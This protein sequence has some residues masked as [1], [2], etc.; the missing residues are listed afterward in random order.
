MICGLHDAQR[1][2]IAASGIFHARSPEQQ[3]IIISKVEVMN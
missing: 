1:S 2:G 3:F